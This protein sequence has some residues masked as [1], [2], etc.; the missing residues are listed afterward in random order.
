MPL[1]LEHVPSVNPSFNTTTPPWVK[2]AGHSGLATGG[3]VAEKTI[4]PVAAGYFDDL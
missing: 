3:S 1:K 4:T 2:Q